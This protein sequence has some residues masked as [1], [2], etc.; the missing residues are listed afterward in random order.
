[1]QTGDP[2]FPLKVSFFILLGHHDQA[3]VD[4]RSVSGPVDLVQ[5]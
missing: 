1:M 5:V 3:V 2:G 4:L